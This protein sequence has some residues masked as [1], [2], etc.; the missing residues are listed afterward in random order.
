VADDAAALLIDSG[1]KTRHIHKRNQRDVERVAEADK[2]RRLI[3]GIDVQHAG[4]E[5]RWLAIIPTGRPCKRP[6]PITMFG[7]NP[8]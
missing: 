7:A 8:G 2:P 5:I 4:E 1:K 3:G 6:K